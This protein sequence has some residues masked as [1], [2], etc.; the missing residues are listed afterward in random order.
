MVGKDD[1]GPVGDEKMPV[2]LHARF[3]Q[4]A[5]FFQECD[6]IEDN[7]IANDAAA[8]GTQH[9]ARHKLQHKLFAVDDDGVAGIVP[10][11]IAG[12]HGKVLRQHVDDLS[13][14]LVAPLGAHDDRSLSFFQFPLRSE[15]AAGTPN[16]CPGVAHFLL[17]EFLL[18]NTRDR[19]EKDVY[20]SSYRGAIAY[21]NAG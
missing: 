1:V 15:N 9:A 21:S 8:S 7:A 3:A 4:R 20:K 2:D 6:G 12:H 16:A 11:G 18:G 5:N 10:A 13:L 14:A 19:A 17:A